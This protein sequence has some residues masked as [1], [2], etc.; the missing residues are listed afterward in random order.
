MSRVRNAVALLVLAAA[1]QSVPLT[2]SRSVN[3]I[4]DGVR[5]AAEDAST[6]RHRV[7]G[8]YA[9]GLERV[10]K[11]IPR[12]DDYLLVGSND[13]GV[14]FFIQYDLAPRRAWN[15]PP[16]FPTLAALRAAGRPPAA[17]RYLVLGH[18]ATEAPEAIALDDVF[19]GPP[20]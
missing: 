9:E 17:P 2:L 13:D 10:R 16:P 8:R 5:G 1:L 18:G 14:L 19:G 11:A 7:F 20:P 12:E 4:L 3:R 15:V 6:A